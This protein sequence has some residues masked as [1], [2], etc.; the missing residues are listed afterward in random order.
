MQD[1]FAFGDKDGKG[2][3]VKLQHPLAVV[4][5]D[6]EATQLIYI[7]DSYNHKVLFVTKRLSLSLSFYHFC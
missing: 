4:C 3:D 5:G 6:N 1:L 7:A 2:R